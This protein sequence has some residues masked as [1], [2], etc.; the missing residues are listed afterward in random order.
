MR[1]RPPAADASGLPPELL[2]ATGWLDIAEWNRRRREWNDTHPDNPLPERPR[3]A[4][5]V[6]DL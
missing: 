6:E 5:R 2:T 1:R 4:F 3:R